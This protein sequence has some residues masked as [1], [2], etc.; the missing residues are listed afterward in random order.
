MAKA[1]N[2][3]TYDT[4]EAWLNAGMLLMEK[5][6]L[7]EL[8]EP[9]RKL[10]AKWRA[11]VGFPFQ[12]PKAIGQCFSPESSA[13]ETVEMWICPTQEEPVTV[14]NILLHESIHATVGTKE[15]HKGE[16]K[17]MAN[18]LG[19]AGKMTSAMVAPDHP[20]YKVLEEVAE[21]LGP[22]PHQKMV[23]TRKK[24]Q[25]GGGW[26]RYV[27]E[28]NEG[29]KVVVSPKMVEEYGPPKD[30]WNRDMIPVTEAG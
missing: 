21:A 3:K 14:L 15:G 10:P 7:K 8:K 9:A 16:F 28:E 23:K 18:Q 20:N 29:F 19:M 22:Y 2:P 30:P 27:S 24:G 6:L 13:S 4:S 11:R 17:K 12:S 1:T 5:R 26:V 25:A